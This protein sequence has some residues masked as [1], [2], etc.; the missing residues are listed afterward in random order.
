MAAIEL[1][2]LRAHAARL[3]D[4]LA[5]GDQKLDDRLAGITQSLPEEDT[6]DQIDRY[7]DEYRRAAT[8]FPNQLRFSLVALTYSV[9]ENRMSAVASAF[10]QL[11][12]S[13]LEPSDF[14]GDS[15]LTR[16]RRC[17]TKAARLNLSADVWATLEPYRVV[18]NTIVNSAGHFQK[19]PPKAVKQMTTDSD[20]MKVTESNGIILADEFADEFIQRIETFYR[21]LFAAW[22]EWN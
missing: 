11:K 16:A 7:N 9:F 17:I 20:A 22:E 13:P 12:K 1:D 19:A 5:K 14:A 18:R 6:E 8:Y 10:L 4:Q 2:E 15:P 21:Q 3:S